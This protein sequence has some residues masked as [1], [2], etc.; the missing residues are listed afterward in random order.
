[1]VLFPAPMASA[2]IISHSVVKN[3]K[4]GRTKMLHVGYYHHRDRQD[5]EVN[6]KP[7]RYSIFIV[8]LNIYM[9]NSTISKSRYWSYE[10][11]SPKVK[12]NDLSCC[13]LEYSH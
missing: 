6:T 10:F 5:H 11:N 8:D 9:N 4:I 3:A 2:L 12:S 7:K 1:M 13:L